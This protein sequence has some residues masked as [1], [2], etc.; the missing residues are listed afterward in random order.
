MGSGPIFFTLHSITLTPLA[1]YDQVL[2]PALGQNGYR[3]YVRLHLAVPR[4]I[5]IS[6][7]S[8]IS[9]TIDVTIVA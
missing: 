4:G 6:F 9:I 1:L 2:Q 7:L 5:F 3:W 8:C